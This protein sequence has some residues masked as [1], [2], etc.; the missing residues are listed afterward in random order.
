MNLY[1]AERAISGPLPLGTFEMRKGAN[2]VYL[3]M[4]GAD[5]RAKGQGLDLLEIIFEKR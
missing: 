5:P 3:Y 2:I 1:A 4:V